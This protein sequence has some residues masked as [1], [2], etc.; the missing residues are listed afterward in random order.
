VALVAFA[1]MF[2]RAVGVS[3]TQAPDWVKGSTDEK[4]R[5]LADIQPRLGTVMMEYAAQVDAAAKAKNWTGYSSLTSQVINACN[6]CDAKVQ[7]A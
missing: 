6:Q 1:L 3:Y 7:M 2:G 4:I 5:K